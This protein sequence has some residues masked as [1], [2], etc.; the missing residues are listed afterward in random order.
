LVTGYPPPWIAVDNWSA[1]ERDAEGAVLIP[2][3]L[4]YHPET[5]DDITRRR[6]SRRRAREGNVTGTRP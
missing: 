4:G 6:S 3:I 5:P 1:D 2:R